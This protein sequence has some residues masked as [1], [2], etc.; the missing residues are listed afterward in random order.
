MRFTSFGITALL[1]AS[2]KGCQE[3]GIDLLLHTI[4]AASPITLEATPS[5][6]VG[7]V[8]VTLRLLNDYGAAVPGGAITAHLEGDAIP[9]DTIEMSV[10]AWGYAS[11]PTTT[12]SAGPFT[13]TPISSQEAAAPGPSVTNWSLSSQLPTGGL[14]PAWPLDGIGS[15]EYLR[16]LSDGLL[17]LG[18]TDA[19]YLPTDQAS[20]PHRVLAMH[21]SIQGGLTSHIDGD[22]VLDA[23]IWTDTEIAVLRGRN[24]GGMGWLGGFSTEAAY[25]VVGV[26]VGDIDG[27]WQADLAV[28]LSDGKSSTVRLMTGDG[29]GGFSEQES[30]D[31]DYVLTDLLLAMS[32]GDSLAEINGVDS[33]TTLIRY[34]NLDGYGWVETGPSRLEP[35]LSSPISFLGAADLDGGGSQDLVLAGPPESQSSLDDEEGRKVV[36][37]TFDGSNYEYKL[38]LPTFHATM[39]DITGDGISDL[40][41]LEGGQA[42]IVTVDD[43]EP[44]FVRRNVTGLPE[45]GPIALLDSDGQ[46]LQ[47]LAVA[48]EGLLLFPGQEGNDPGTWYPWEPSWSGYSLDAT[49]PAIQLMDLDHDGIVDSVASFTRDQDSGILS[50]ET[51][52]LEGDAGESPSFVSGAGIDFSESAQPLDLLWCDPILQALVEDDE[53]VSLL[54]M[55]MDPYSLATTS[56]S[57]LGVNASRIACGS[58]DDFATL[59]LLNSDG[60][61]VYLDQD[62]EVTG[63]EQLGDFQDVA[64]GDPDGDGLDELLTCDDSQCSILVIDV[65][66]DGL[67][68][69]ITSMEGLLQVDGWGETTSLAGGGTLTAADLQGDGI[70]DVLATDG[71]LIWLYQGL[72]G[73][74]APAAGLHTRQ[75]EPAGPASAGDIDGDG[76]A[77]LVIVTTEG[78]I[79]HLDP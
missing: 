14:M 72:P 12:V 46:K 66:G 11:Q 34:A 49:G 45:S 55:Q 62:L 19:W 60:E 44:S 64:A 32:D 6:G 59:A 74:L 56:S 15:M 2:C 9:S 43:D 40:V 58:F 54:S 38:T 65:D 8:E 48:S 41:F 17:L 73:A 47:D 7:Q 35:G 42:W 13:V 29:T 25:T 22:G 68:E 53:E 76:K 50:M 52:A 39:G 1:L 75:Q 79:L 23:V 63:S 78:N 3:Q 4:D 71:S 77:E 24:G 36:Y 16:A 67:D 21:D 70:L 57:D 27:D 26:S 51:W 28:A 18:T 20:P 10:D 5:V 37:Y 61:V 69:V 31:F 30:I 33:T